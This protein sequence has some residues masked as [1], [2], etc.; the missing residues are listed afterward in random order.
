MT[1]YIETQQGQ[2]DLILQLYFT[3]RLNFLLHILHKFE[4]GIGKKLIIFSFKI[5]LCPS[6]S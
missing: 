3:D 5:D 6:K 2:F 4:K 1:Q